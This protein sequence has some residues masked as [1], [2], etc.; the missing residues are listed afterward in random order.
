MKIVDAGSEKKQKSVKS[1]VKSK[2]KQNFD[3]EDF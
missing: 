2:S 3:E 1:S